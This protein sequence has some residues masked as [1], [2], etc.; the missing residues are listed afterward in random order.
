MASRSSV[1][2][3]PTGGA[4]AAADS[5]DEPEQLQYKV[6]GLCGYLCGP[7][8]LDPVFVVVVVVDM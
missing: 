6:C 2:A 7:L 1:A 3:A 5:D 4:A 8:M